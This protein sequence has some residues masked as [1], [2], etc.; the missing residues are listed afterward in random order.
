[1]VQ[2]CTVWNG[3][4]ICDIRIEVCAGMAII[5][6]SFKVR[7]IWQWFVRFYSHVQPFCTYGSMYLACKSVWI[8]GIVSC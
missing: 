1:M 5:G 8:E 6:C 3:G 7:T 4:P 2:V